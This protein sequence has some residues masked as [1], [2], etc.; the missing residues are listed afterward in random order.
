ME[1]TLIA[2]F[3]NAPYIASFLAGVLTFFSPCVLALIPAYLSYV[4]GL[5]I[6]QLTDE[7][8]T[9]KSRVKVIEAS[10]LFIAGF[11]VIFILLGASMANLIE[12]VFAY[13][14]V[15][16]LA[17]TIIIIFGLHLMGIIS[18]KFLNYEARADFGALDKKQDSFWAKIL[19]TISP[20]LLGVS[21]AL[22]WTPCVGPI[23]T[24]IISMG[25]QE[26][27]KSLTLMIIYALG[28]AIPFLLSA[29]LTSKALALFIKIKRYFRAI[30]IIGGVLLILIGIGMFK[31]G[32]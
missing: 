22:G 1:D 25:A 31:S 11:S 16:Y 7:N 12:D 32:F 27:I 8:L 4:S 9:L 24:A 17:G 30:E 29:I 21:F 6:K 14:W 28:L 2:L 5:S 26:E 23:F 10:L 3:K 15:K 13:E 20:F 19:H 18:I